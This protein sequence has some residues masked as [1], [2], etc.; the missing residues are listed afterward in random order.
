MGAEQILFLKVGIAVCVS[1]LAYM[2]KIKFD[3]RGQAAREKIRKA[4]YYLRGVTHAE[5]IGFEKANTFAKESI[6][7]N[8]KDEWEEGFVD[9]VEHYENVLKDLVLEDKSHEEL[10][11][12]HALDKKISERKDALKKYGFKENIRW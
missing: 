8:H 10:R 12:N 4:N 11:Y 9:Y 2:F 5:C 3:K 6:P 7:V 1:L